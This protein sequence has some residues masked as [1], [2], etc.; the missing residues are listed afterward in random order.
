M[1]GMPRGACR[2]IA[3]SCQFNESLWQPELAMS[4]QSSA[5]M[6]MPTVDAGHMA[7]GKSASTGAVRR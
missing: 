6:V 7:A 4:A 1:C 3:S 5:A 2:R